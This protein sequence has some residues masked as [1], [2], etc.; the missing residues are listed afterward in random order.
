MSDS[1]SPAAESSAAGP[2]AR[3]RRHYKQYVLVVL[4][5]IVLFNYVDRW[6]FGLVLQ[7]IK[8]ELE[9]TD[10]QLGFLTGIAFALFY[11]VVGVPIARWAD[12]GNR[13]AIISLTAAL[14]SVG[15][16]LCA[17]ATSFEQLLLIRIGVA[18][19]EAGCIPPALSL[20]ADYFNRAERPRAAAV[21]LIG[22][23]FSF[24]VGFL[25]A[26]WLN[27]LYGWRVMFVA[28]AMPGVALCILAWATLREPRRSASA[29]T[30]NTANDSPAA[31]MFREVCAK[32]WAIPTFRLLLLY[33][34]VAYFFTYGIVQWQPAFFI[35]SHGMGTSELGVWLG[36]SYGI[37][38]MLG[39]Y[40]GGAWSS[41][42]AARNERLQLRV[43]A[44]VIGCSAV[45]AT[46][47]Y[48][49]P[50]PHVAFGLIALSSAGL[51]MVSSPWI[52]MN[53]T[54]VP[55]RMRAVAA[56]LTFLVSNLIGMGFGPLLAGALSDAFQPW[57]GK[58]SLRYALLTLAPGYCC[59]AWLLWRA[60]RT[61][62]RDLEIAQ[63][64]THETDHAS[65]EKV[66]DI[67]A[68]RNS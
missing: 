11:S 8:T 25:L 58:E 50:S 1:V 65:H 44:L 15:V 5:L 21:Y 4:T 27:E 7:D 43:S 67:Q 10:T 42:Y 2:D 47:T 61:V 31:P 51:A 19:G 3:G 53:Q 33:N 46:L 60:S 12:R 63:P 29:W 38:G 20:M 18:V 35:R 16:A 52:A 24:I 56:A 30:R 66:L 13:V 9:L 41:N 23:S 36:F 59:A 40:L 32:L 22:S 68:A 17:A 62:T 49:S 34:S 54:L 45:F 6:A 64:G 28:L 57:A 14:W 55:E 26:G 48:I 37:G 39:A